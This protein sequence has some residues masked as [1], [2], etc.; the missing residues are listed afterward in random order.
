MDLSRIKTLLFGR[1]PGFPQLAASPDGDDLPPDGLT[2]GT[3]YIG[4]QGT[5]KT[6]SLARH[7]VASFKRH[8]DRALFVLDW[9]G[10]ITDHLLRLVL[11]EPPEVREGLLKR[12]VYDAMGHPE[13]VIP[14]PEFSEDYGT[15]FEEQVQRVSQNLVKLA[16]ELVKDAPFLAGLGLREI[17]PQVGRLLV[18]I[19]NE[20]GET[21]QITE[22]RN[23]LADTGLLREKLN[24][25]GFQAPEARWFL[26]RLYLNLAPNEREL[27]S[28]A[29]VALLGAIEPR[30]LR[31]R[32]GFYRPGWTPQEAIERGLLVIVDGARLINRK[33][34]QH[35]LFTQA[36]SLIMAE[37]NKR[38][39]G[40]PRDRPVS[41]VMDEVYSLL[42]IPGMAEEV[43][44]LSPLYRSRKLQLYLVLQAL[45][46]LA[47]SL[48]QQI[49]SIGNIVCFA[50]SNVDEA[51]ELAQQLFHYEPKSVKLE[52]KTET[53]QP[54]L[55]PDRGQY[56]AIANWMQRLNHR[57][58]IVRRYR[59]EKVLDPYIHHVART[60]ENPAAAVSEEAVME[61]KERLLKERGV[62]VRE[63]LEVINQ[64]A[65]VEIVKRPPKVAP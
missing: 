23:L 10:S 59:S 32:V 39:P 14:L 46:Q 54:V 34:A 12:L 24:T 11:R 37:I 26:E 60:R 22:A 25:F 48:R 36:Y 58:C 16:P 49:W 13:W 19:R 47:P 51:Y 64:R 9:S 45:S 4:R 62:R 56:L 43:G 33:A 35:Y 52:A 50:V 30:E 29:L 18:A 40:D 17:A 65:P 42:S 55:E 61:L 21:W 6:S 15:S 53:Q 63:A 38:Q 31:A 44:M 41:L 7:L 20:H 27:R 28:Y 1:A 5:G 8:P 3:L 57:E 2:M